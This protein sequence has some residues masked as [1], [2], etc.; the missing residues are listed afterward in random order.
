MAHRL[1]VGCFEHRGDEVDRL[2]SRT[3]TRDLCGAFLPVFP[4]HRW[5]EQHASCN[6]GFD[7]NSYDGGAFTV[8]AAPAYALG[9]RADPLRWSRHRLR[10]SGGTIRFSDLVGGSRRAIANRGGDFSFTTTAVPVDCIG[11][12]TDGV[13]SMASGSRAAGM[14][15]AVR[16]AFRARARPSATHRATTARFGP[17]VPSATRITETVP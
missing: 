9:A 10:R 12:V 16:P 2:T 5:E 11:T 1:F 7:R 6:R 8:G 15:A 17:E 3:P 4:I 14:A 13:S